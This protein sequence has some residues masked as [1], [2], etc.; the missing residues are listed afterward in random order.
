MKYLNNTYTLEIETI[1]PVSIGNN[2]PDSSFAVYFYDN[3]NLHYLDFQKLK[4]FN[5]S[6]SQIDKFIESINQ[7]IENNKVDFKLLFEEVFQL[8]IST[9]FNKSVLAKELEA[10]KIRV[11]KEIIKT[12]DNA[13]ISGSSLKGAIKGSLFTHYIIKNNGIA[14]VKNS[15]NNNEKILITELLLD[16]EISEKNK[17]N[18]LN[19]C[20]KD[21]DKQFF[22]Q[23]ISSKKATSSRKNIKSWSAR[24]KIEDSTS[25]ENWQVVELSRIRLSNGENEI[26]YLSEVIP[27][28]VKLCSVLSF[29][30]KNCENTNL[31]NCKVIHSSENLIELLRI[32]HNTHIMFLKDEKNKLEALEHN[33]LQD[34]LNWIDKLLAYDGQNEF[35][36]RIGS[37]KTWF[38][39]SIG[40]ALQKLNISSYEQFLKLYMLDDLDSYNRFP[41]TRALTS[42]SHTPMGWVKVRVKNFEKAAQVPDDIKKLLR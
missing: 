13:Y 42:V 8:P 19:E 40:L 32:V 34:Y 18:K 33:N 6:T 7:E 24:F 10:G 30:T 37:G 28:G 11:L 36:L 9:I 14:T 4:D 39:N 22:G 16:K 2:Q 5:I 23:N 12:N 17:K 31:G 25:V 26:P 29:D 20:I 21:L 1:T 27:N 38:Q 41:S 15:D 3:D 35:L